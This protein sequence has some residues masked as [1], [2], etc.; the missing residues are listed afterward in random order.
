MKDDCSDC[1]MKDECPGYEESE[2]ANSEDKDTV[3]EVVLSF[4][5]DILTCCI[6]AIIAGVS[7]VGFFYGT[8]ILPI[9]DAWMIK[10][11]VVIAGIAS[12]GVVIKYLVLWKSRRG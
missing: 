10:F 8:D 1:E 2:G 9:S 4:I 11:M 3:F 6:G 7:V 12:V 5:G